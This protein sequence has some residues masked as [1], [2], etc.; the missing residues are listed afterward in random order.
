M[1]H[2]FSWHTHQCVNVTKTR[3]DLSSVPLASAAMRALWLTQTIHWSYAKNA[4]LCNPCAQHYYPL[5]KKAACLLFNKCYISFCT[6]LC[7]FFLIQCFALYLIIRLHIPF[8]CQIR[9]LS[10]TSIL[11]IY[12][13]NFLLLGSISWHDFF[14]RNIWV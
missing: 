13:F 5:R 11:R 6:M 4:K 12:K 9:N 14:Q 3:L 2:L 7:W 1:G 8:V 10:S